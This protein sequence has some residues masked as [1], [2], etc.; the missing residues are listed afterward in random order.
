M[1]YGLIGTASA[2]VLATALAS[3][4]CSGSED[5][6]EGANGGGGGTGGGGAQVTTVA[7]SAALGALTTQDATKLCDDTFAYFR[8][9]IPVANIC[10][11][12][13]L[14]F[15]TSSSAPS[16][17]E[18]RQF[19]SDKETGCLGDPSTAFTNTICSPFPGDCTAT[20]AEYSTC[21][22][23]TV[24]MFN[25]TVEA[26]PVCS[27]YAMSLRQGVW[28]AQAATPPSCTFSACPSVFPPS[29]LL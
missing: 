29:P 28:D 19:C 11:W 14:S 25:Q 27:M 2:M 8:T 12:R 26:L 6:G 15:A 3:T 9:A 23:D 16:D 4:G 24:T 20:V 13:G 18:L 10:K 7:S 5:G 21:I 17:V 1:R 22:R